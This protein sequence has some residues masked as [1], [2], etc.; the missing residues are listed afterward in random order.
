MRHHL[1]RQRYRDPSATGSDFLLTIGKFAGNVYYMNDIMKNADR[2]AFVAIK[3]CN[4]QNVGFRSL[5]DLLSAYEVAHF[6]ATTGGEINE[7][8][9]LR[10]GQLIEPTFNARGYRRTPVTFQNGDVANHQ[11]I[12]T[13]MQ[14]LLDISR[15]GFDSDDC[16]QWT[17]Y[18]LSI[19]PFRDGN[20]RCAWILYNWLRGTLDYPLPLPDF[21]F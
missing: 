9:I 1:L 8:M 19:H 5:V 13:A 4:R 10:L 16:Y 21:Q 14:N 11:H 15:D 2:I 3:E 17:K 12:E 6:Q 20:G 18:F 7:V